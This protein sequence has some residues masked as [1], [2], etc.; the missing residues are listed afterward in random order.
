MQYVIYRGVMDWSWCGFLVLY[1]GPA[2]FVYCTVMVLWSGSV[3]S[4]LY[5]AIYSSMSCARLGESESLLVLS[6]CLLQ[7]I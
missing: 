2:P 4:L 6:D 5:E 3:V 1:M 7:I